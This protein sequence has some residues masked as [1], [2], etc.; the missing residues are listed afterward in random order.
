MMGIKLIS[1]FILLGTSYALAPGGNGPHRE[2]V[3]KKGSDTPPPAPLLPPAA[4]EVATEL[5]GVSAEDIETAQQLVEEA[6]INME[7]EI[8]A[9]A[10]ELEQL[11]LSSVNLT[12]AE[13][14]VDE[15]VEV[16]KDAASQIEEVTDEVM[17]SL[18]EDEKE[19]SASDLTESFPTEDATNAT[20]LMLPGGTPFDL[21]C[22]NPKSE[23]FQRLKCVAERK[24]FRIA[25]GA[26]IDAIKTAII[27]ALT[28][29]VKQLIV[30]KV[31]AFKDFVED[32][33]SS[34]LLV[35]AKIELVKGLL[36]K[37]TKA[38]IETADTTVM[39][40]E[41]KAM[42]EVMDETHVTMIEVQEVDDASLMA[43]PLV[44]LFESLAALVEKMPGAEGMDLQE[45]A[46]TEVASFGILFGDFKTFLLQLKNVIRFCLLKHDSSTTSH[47]SA[48][49]SKASY[50]SEKESWKEKCLGA[51]KGYKLSS[52][53]LGVE[54]YS[55]QMADAIGMD[56]TAMESVAPQDQDQDT[57]EA[58]TIS[59]SKFQAYDSSGMRKSFPAAISSILVASAFVLLF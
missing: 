5:A 37:L 29:F 48:K 57:T 19:G 42:E 49:A 43:E 16:V 54:D 47:K 36:T 21:D 44:S 38:G 2:L 50:K 40:K 30:M 9:V 58:T 8:V 53:L 41:V 26:A 4:A 17:T 59:V 22:F 55:E 45:N 51:L 32:V 11:S 23:K 6:V 28:A 39:L 3:I 52:A 56:F 33:I 24:A 13:V 12:T 34:I 18:E 15:V 14:D 27:Q 25:I 7:D 31:D 20:A 10:E 46:M 1:S 35:K